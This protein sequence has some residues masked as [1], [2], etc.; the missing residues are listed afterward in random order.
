MLTVCNGECLTAAALRKQGIEKIN[1]SQGSFPW[2]LGM[3]WTWNFVFLCQGSRTVIFKGHLE[4]GTWK[5]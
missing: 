4:I 5:Y 2:G 3:L 1:S